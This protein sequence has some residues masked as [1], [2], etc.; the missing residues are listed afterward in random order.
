MSCFF[1]N[2]IPP[3]PTVDLPS[4]GVNMSAHSR[5][6]VPLNFADATGANM[7]IARHGFRWLEI[8][9]TASGGF[10][11]SKHDSIADQAVANGVE[12]IGTLSNKPSW[13]GPGTGNEP[14]S[15]AN[16]SRYYSY[17]AA[18]AARYAGKVKCWQ[19]FNEPNINNW[20]AAQYGTL[21]RGAS[22]AIRGV[23]P[24]VLISAP[25]FAGM[26]WNANGP[27]R[28]AWFAEFMTTSGNQAAMDVVSFHMYSRPNSPESGSAASGP[29]HVAAA[30]SL[31]RYNDWGWSGPSWITE[32]GYYTNPAAGPDPVSDADRTRWIVRLA[33][34]IRA[35]FNRFYVYRM[36]SGTN[37]TSTFD[38]EGML[39][40]DGTHRDF[41]ESMR[42]LGSICDR[43]V[44][45]YSVVSEDPVWV[46]RFN[47]P[48]GI[49][50][51]ILWRNTGTSSYTLTGLTATVRR[52]TLMGTETI[53]ATSGGQLSVSTG[54]DPVYIETL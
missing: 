28:N 5:S 48:N 24:N 9:P 47:K 26:P 33:V 30:E 22:A 12:L 16:F 42:I 10:S 31:V 37:P 39:N 13:A 21:L 32:G 29:F 43:T 46:Y 34:I 52:T 8:E 20:T 15:T 25:T 53:V 2:V 41:Y 6:L 1:Q 3:S 18:T 35:Y 54:V 49:F 36:Y 4:F 7:F 19:I 40:P 23:D 27:T 11:W 17:A 44:S 14:P 51:Y 45:S 50:G 38:D